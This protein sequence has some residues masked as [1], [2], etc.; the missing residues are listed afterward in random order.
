MTNIST[1]FS[2]IGSS[3]IL[4]PSVVFKF[5][6][7]IIGVMGNMIVIIH[8][9]IISKEK[10]ATSYL[11]A[12]LAMADLLVCLTFYPI[13]ITEFIRIILNIDSDQDLFCKLSR[14][15]IWAF[16]FAS[17][18]TLLVITIDRYFYIVRPLKYP[19]IITKR[20]VFAAILGIWLSNCCIFIVLKIY[21]RK[22]DSKLRGLCVVVSAHFFMVMDVFLGCLPLVI[23]FVLNYQIF[24]VARKQRKRILT[25]EAVTDGIS[26]EQSSKKL[27]G[28]LRFLVG[29]K[30]AKTFLIVVMVLTFCILTPTIVG[31][32]L[33][34]FCSESCCQIWYV[35]LHYELYGINWI[36]NAFIYG[37]K[38]I[39]YR[40]AYK[41]ILFE[42]FRRRRKE[43]S[44]SQN[45]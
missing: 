17:V 12:N 11:V 39:K 22:F 26:N 16:L 13:W 41:N 1:H 9:I 31:L 7:I 18:A 28:V 32:T 42:M 10:T 19:L 14:S 33:T 4:L 6:A 35:I 29:L 8:A 21:S 20:R 34:I 30:G 15:T 38:H 24:S 43:F 40:K 5:V 23:M 37:M 45:I 36:V 2:A 3:E 44:H 27:I 25:E